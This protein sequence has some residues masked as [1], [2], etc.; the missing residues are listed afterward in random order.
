[1]FVIDASALLALILNERGADVVR[2][3]PRGS[4][5]SVINLGEVL[6]RLVKLQHDAENALDDIIR[7]PLRIRK[8]REEHALAVAQMMPLT[9]HL[10]LS[11]GDRACLVQAQ[12]SKMPVLTADW[13]MSKAEVGVDIRMIR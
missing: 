3:A 7:M 12:F 6:T 11:Y 1:M 13:R 9:A 10:G 4:E 8:F 2:A 5:V